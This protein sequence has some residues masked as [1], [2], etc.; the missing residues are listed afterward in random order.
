MKTLYKVVAKAPDLVQ[1]RADDTLSEEYVHYF[2]KQKAHEGDVYYSFNDLVTAMKA[3]PSGTFKLGADLNATNVPTPNKEYVPGKFSGHLT[4]VDGKQYSIH[5]MARQLFGNIEGGSVK[6]INLAN[7]NI[8]M[9]WIND[10]SALAKTVKN[11][12]VE[13]I[14]V[15]GSILGNNSIAGIVNKIDR[16]G[17]LRNVAFIGKLQAVGDRDW[18]FSWYCW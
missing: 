7:V 2:E 17:L 15:T 3:N 16:G 6:N 9:P 11:A 13:N 12:T 10:I 8:N 18:N 4:S 14:K 1:R 5:N